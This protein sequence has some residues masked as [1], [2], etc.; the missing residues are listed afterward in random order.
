M[1]I[2]SSYIA[3]VTKA[4]KHRLYL[5]PEGYQHP[6]EVVRDFVSNFVKNKNPSLSLSEIVGYKSQIVQISKHEFLF[7][8]SEGEVLEIAVCPFTNEMGSMLDAELFEG[9][10]VPES[11]TSFSAV[12]ALIFDFGVEDCCGV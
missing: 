1:T 8:Y 12:I 3:V 7:S 9:F 4:G 6:I 10:E 11:H 2:P 5:F